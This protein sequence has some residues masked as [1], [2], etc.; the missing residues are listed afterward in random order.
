M[1][2]SYARKDGASL[3]HS[4]VRDLELCAPIHYISKPYFKPSDSCDGSDIL[5]FI[6]TSNA[7]PDARRKRDL[8]SCGVTGHV[9]TDSPVERVSVGNRHQSRSNFHSNPIP[10]HYSLLPTSAYQRIGRQSDV[11]D[12]R[13]RTRRSK[14][15]ILGHELC[16]ALVFYVKGDAPPRP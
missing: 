9:I 8:A 2:I 1:F 4:L 14:Y 10:S 15:L 13:L 16:P 5:Q 3:A 6:G 12:E 11:R 7:I